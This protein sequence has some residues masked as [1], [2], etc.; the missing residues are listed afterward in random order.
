M[1]S[2]KNR[3]GDSEFRKQQSHAA[4]HPNSDRRTDCRAQPVHVGVRH[5]LRLYRRPAIDG[6]RRR[7]AGAPDAGEAAEP[8][9]A[10]L[11]GGGGGARRHHGGV[12]RPHR[13]LRPRRGALRRQCALL[14]RPHGRPRRGRRRRHLHGTRRVTT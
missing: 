12:R 13:A 4:F 6:R 10:S 3:G 8:P 1:D 2:Y 11:H 14:A 7:L 5:A 9:G